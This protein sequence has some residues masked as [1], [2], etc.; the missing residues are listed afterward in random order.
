M[1]IESTTWLTHKT[2]LQDYIRKRVADQHA[3]EDILQDVL[4]Q[5][6]RQRHELR[7]PE[8]LSPWLFKIARHRIIDYYR[9]RK[10]MDALPDNLP[11][12]V[13]ETDAVTELAACLPPLLRQLPDT[14]RDA[15]VLADLEGL[16]QQQVSERLG[17]SLSGA[18]SRIQRGREK[19]RQAVTRC[20]ELE[21]ANGRIVDYRPREGY[22]RTP[23]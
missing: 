1:T 19:L 18:K 10:P 21:T 20:C 3:V 22:C 6:H 4:L 5:A 7:D 17:L 12:P 16:P 23:C 8:R 13:D 2:R 15:L 11:N 9:A 14:Y